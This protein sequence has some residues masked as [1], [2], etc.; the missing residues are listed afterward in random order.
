MHHYTTGV[1]VRTRSKVFKYLVMLCDIS[2]HMKSYEEAVQY[3]KRS[4]E[5]ANSRAGLKILR[6]VITSGIAKVNDKRRSSLLSRGSTLFNLHEDPNKSS[7]TVCICHNLEELL[8]EIDIAIKTMNLKMGDGNSILMQSS[9]DKSIIFPHSNSA[10]GVMNKGRSLL[11][12]NTNSSLK[13]D[14]F[15]PST[16]SSEVVESKS[17][18]LIS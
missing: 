14:N 12:R 6:V 18:C 5:F 9:Q 10:L 17:M 7:S 2:I 4:M 3:G 13:I 11:R 1:S 15:Q 8:K 16:A